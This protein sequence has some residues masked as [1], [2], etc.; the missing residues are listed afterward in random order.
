MFAVNIVRL[1]LIGTLALAVSAHA[2]VFNDAA[3][4]PEPVSNRNGNFVITPS[5]PETATDPN[6]FELSDPIVEFGTDHAARMMMPVEIGGFGPYPFIIDTGSQRTI[7]ATELAERLALPALPSVGI[8]SLAGPVTLPSVRL[9]A[10][11]FGGHKIDS[12]AALTIKRSDMGSLGVI[13]LD[14][15][16]DKRLIMDFAKRRMEVG[17]SRRAKAVRDDGDTIVVR[18][19]SR[20]GQLILVNS[21]LDSQRVNV[22]LDTGA[23]LSVGNMALFSK[24]KTNRLLVPPEPT[25][26]VTV[27]GAEVPALF[28][29]VRRLTIGSATLDNVPMVFLDAAPFE[30][31]GLG[32]KPAMLLGMGML[33]L[34]DRIAIDFG[35]RHV[36][37]HLAPSEAEQ[38][39]MRLADRMTAEALA[40]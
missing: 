24:L 32:D 35:H 9:D 37:F 8:I 2:Q 38:E 13:G 4:E 39:R 5:N 40:R 16:V 29:V 30:Q 23:E 21:R 28:T 27:T 12:L 18:A 1:A 25:K 34:F 11:H 6:L 20:F 7:V 19:R 15:L 33:R 3:A 26:L 36:D 31:L 10:M 22:I 14:S 17:E